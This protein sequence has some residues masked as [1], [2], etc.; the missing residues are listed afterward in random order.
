MKSPS[1]P[2]NKCPLLGQNSTSVCIASIFNVP[3]CEQCLHIYIQGYTKGNVFNAPSPMM[4]L[5]WLAISNIIGG[6]REVSIKEAVPIPE[7]ARYCSPKSMLRVITCTVWTSST[8]SGL[9]RACN[10]HLLQPT[11]AWSLNLGR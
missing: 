2:L 1:Y 6:R 3:E 4:N 9:V 8:V 10:A 5:E 11:S 7:V